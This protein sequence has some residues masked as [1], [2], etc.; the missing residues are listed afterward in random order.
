VTALT[1]IQDRYN[2]VIA[3]YLAETVSLS[4]AA[5]LLDLSWLDLRTRCVR[6]DV[7]LRTAP[8]DL[9]EARADLEAARSWTSQP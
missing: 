2:L 5:E 9:A 6:L 8:G 4:R 1:N 3:H 7:P